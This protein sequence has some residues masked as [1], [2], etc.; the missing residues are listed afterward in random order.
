LIYGLAKTFNVRKLVSDLR[1]GA[2]RFVS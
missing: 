2:K 1:G